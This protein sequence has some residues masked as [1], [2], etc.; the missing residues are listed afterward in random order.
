MVERKDKL[1]Q[2]RIT[3]K[4]KKRIKEIAEKQGKTIS[5]LLCNYIREIIEKDDFKCNYS[6]KIEKR[7]N[8]FEKKLKILKEKIK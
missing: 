7:T 4:D 5:E 3:S 2:I 6:D 8:L 1:I